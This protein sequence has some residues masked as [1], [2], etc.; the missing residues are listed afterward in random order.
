[1]DASR[2]E[3]LCSCIINLIQLAVSKRCTTT[4]GLA[5]LSG[6]SEHTVSNYFRSAMRHFGVETR[7]EAV[8]EALARGLI[9]LDT[10]GEG[11]GPRP[12]A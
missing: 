9:T 7:A 6:L 3:Q 11:E 12:P 1:M 8:I 2:D 10:D 5:R 4:E